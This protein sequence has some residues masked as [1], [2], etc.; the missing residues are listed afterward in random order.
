MQVGVLWYYKNEIALNKVSQ[1]IPL[2]LLFI[3]EILSIVIED[4][5]KLMILDLIIKCVMKIVEI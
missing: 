2:R 1:N 4:N 5:V 3:S